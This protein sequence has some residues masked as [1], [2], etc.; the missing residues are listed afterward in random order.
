MFI[1]IDPGS[2]GCIAI[3]NQNKEVVAVHD[4]VDEHSTCDFLSDIKSNYDD[5]FCVLERV[6]S[7]P[8]QGVS[9]VFAFG[10]N[11][12][13]YK[14]IL[15]ALKVSYT[16]VTPQAWQ[17][18]VLPVAESDKDKKKRSLVVCRRLYPESLYFKREK[19]HNR[20]DAVL[21]ALHAAKMGGIIKKNG[22]QA[23]SQQGQ[24]SRGFFRL[25]GRSCFSV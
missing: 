5:V 16:T 25:D 3:V 11:Y 2:S 10:A 6:H 9:S 22:K 15:A 17:K 24:D 1:G 21:I 12:G 19:D 4:W 18:G 7:M 20:A 8:G 23:S 14:G 13:A